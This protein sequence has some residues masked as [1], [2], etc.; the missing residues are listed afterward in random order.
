MAKRNT[1]WQGMNPD[2]Q[3]QL[4]YDRIGLAMWWLAA[5]A[6]EGAALLY[7]LLRGF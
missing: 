3:L 1:K 6:V 2:H 4:I 5:L 7:I